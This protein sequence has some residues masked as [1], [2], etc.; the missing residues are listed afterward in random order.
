V[1]CCC[2]QG[3][4]SLETLAP[5]SCSPLS[6]ERECESVRSESLRSLISR[7][8]GVFLSPNSAHAGTSLILF[9]SLPIV[10]GRRAPA[11]RPR[12]LA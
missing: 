12:V 10:G 4:F 1:V 6:R 5:S 9:I 8:R 7:D 2:D 11:I 3:K